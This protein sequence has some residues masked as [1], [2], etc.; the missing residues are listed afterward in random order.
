M[1]KQLILIFI[2][3]LTG[4]LATAQEIE[5]INAK[6]LNS[7]IQKYIKKN[8]EGYKTVEAHKYNVLFEITMKKGSATETLVFDKE[9]NFLHKK[10]EADARMFSMQTRQSLAVGDVESNITKYIKKNYEGYKI[11]EAFV[12]D[13]TFSAKIVKGESTETLLFDKDGK[14]EKKL[15]AKPHP[16]AHKTDSIPAKAK[17]DSI[18]PPAEKAK[19]DSV[20][21]NEAA[22]TDSMKK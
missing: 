14:F 3:I 9:G 19:H 16:V 22:P 1:K 10:T 11:T 2:S 5:T 7:D 6:D 4:M 12:Y 8:F 15:T 13:E 20:P 18:P 17:H 21:H